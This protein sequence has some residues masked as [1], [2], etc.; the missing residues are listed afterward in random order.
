MTTAGHNL[1]P[2][3][4]VVIVG[5]AGTGKSKAINSAE[6]FVRKIPE[7]TIGPTSMTMASLVDHLA[8]AKKTIIEKVGTARDYNSMY[9]MADELSA[10]MDQYDSGLIAGLT[11]F[12]D[13]TEY[14]QARR[15]KDIHVKIKNPQLNILSGSTPSN[16][17][18]FTPEWAWEQGFTSRIILVYSNERPIID[19]FKNP[20]KAVPDAMVT[21]L[22]KIASLRGQFGWD[23]DYATLMWNWKKLGFPPV[24]DHPK[25]EHYNSRRF[26]HAL[27]LAMIANVD[28][29]DT[30]Y[31][32]R[33]DFNKSMEWILE[34][35]ASMPGIFSTGRGSADSKAIDEIMH[36]IR[37]HPNGIH[38]TKIVN[39]ARLHIEYA[40]SIGPILKVMEQSGLIIPVMKDEFDQTTYKPGPIPR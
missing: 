3:L 6:F 13:C 1:Y 20:I 10:F 30:M 39:Y 26:S 8:D 38:Q 4:Y 15:V 9:I 36:F 14:S 32:T 16:L 24:P 31:L 28:R 33:E 27:K 18:R 7:L 11:K 12:F 5:D 19:I 22:H 21:D 29:G 35:E 2:N 37:K 25:L 40:T 34:A 23:E 17:L